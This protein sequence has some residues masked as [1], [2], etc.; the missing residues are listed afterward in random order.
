MNFMKM[1]TISTMDNEEHTRMLKK[2]VENM[3][4]I[5]PPNQSNFRVYAII[6]LTDAKGQRIELSGTNSEW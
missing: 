5:K 6:V 2:C 3:M 4:R 1:D